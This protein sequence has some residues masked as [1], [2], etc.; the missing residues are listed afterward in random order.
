V[1]INTKG[2]TVYLNARQLLNRL[3]VDWS[4]DYIDMPTDTQ[5]KQGRD[6]YGQPYT[7]YLLPGANQEIHIRNVSGAHSASSVLVP[8]PGHGETSK[9]F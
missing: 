1:K 3:Q 6:I 9:L 7:A 5:V 4:E 2:L 8:R